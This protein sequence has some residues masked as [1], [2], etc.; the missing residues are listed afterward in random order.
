[1]NWLNKAAQIV[2]DK[3]GMNLLALDVRG[4]SSLT[5][6]M[7]IAEG[8][9]SKHV[10]HIAKALI[11]D[12]EKK[13]YPP[14]YVEGLEEGDWVIVD[15]VDFMVHLFAPNLRD[16]YQLEKIWPQSKLFDLSI[17]TSSEQFQ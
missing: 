9:V 12:F 15:F 8:S 16:Y 3:K 1:M 2:Y 5:D 17:D 13:G 6:Y 11:A 4:L 14:V 7:L 10:S